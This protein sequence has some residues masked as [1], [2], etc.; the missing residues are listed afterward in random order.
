MSHITSLIGL[1]STPVT[2]IHTAVVIASPY[3]SLPEEAHI[4]VLFFICVCVYVYLHVSAFTS[5]SPRLLEVLV[6]S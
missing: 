4:Y 5:C 3:L 2:Y 1:T 6:T